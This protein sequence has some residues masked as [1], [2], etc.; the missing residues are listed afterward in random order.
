V[1]TTE[2][3]H[4]ILYH[5]LF[6]PNGPLLIP[7]SRFLKKSESL[8]HLICQTYEATCIMKQVQY[9]LDIGQVKQIFATKKNDKS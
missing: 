3:R 5:N 1:T 6:L 8:D 4:H 2:K 9:L 7:S